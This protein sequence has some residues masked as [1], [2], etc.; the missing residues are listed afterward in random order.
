MDK[1]KKEKMRNWLETGMQE[2]NKERLTREKNDVERS[3]R[4][5]N[6]INH[7]KNMTDLEIINDANLKKIINEFFNRLAEIEQLKN[8]STNKKFLR[9]LKKFKKLIELTLDEIQG[10][11]INLIIDKNELSKKLEFF[12]L[13]FEK[14]KNYK[15]TNLKET[16]KERSAREKRIE[17]A[18]PY[19]QYGAPLNPRDKDY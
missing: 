18:S 1:N 15:D 19:R 2:T 7:G 4:E 3:E 17:D 16:N 10:E 5:E 9:L 8:S 13:E 11:Q 14:I 6:L 12:D